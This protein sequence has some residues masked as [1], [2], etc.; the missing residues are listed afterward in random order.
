MID[1]GGIDERATTRLPAALPAD[2][3]HRIVL[4]IRTARDYGVLLETEQRTLADPLVPRWSI[5]FVNLA[6]EHVA[7]ACDA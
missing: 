2:V 7:G 4:R 6:H 1:V 3:D 5:K